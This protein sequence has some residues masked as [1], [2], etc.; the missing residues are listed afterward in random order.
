MK[1]IRD[2]LL[3]YK[4]FEKKKD[5]RF[6]LKAAFLVLA[7]IALGVYIGNLLFGDNS[8]EMM[9]ALKSQRERLQ[10]LTSSLKEENAK[11]QRKYFE[12]K[13]IEVIDSK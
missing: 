3:D 2:T 8:L 11:L 6:Y 5:G 13:Q 7:V 4:E 9:M 12:L 1:D 10:K